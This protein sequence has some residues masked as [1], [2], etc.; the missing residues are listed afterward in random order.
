MHDVQISSNSAL[1][2]K[3]IELV[4]V[5]NSLM[6]LAGKIV[7]ELEGHL[8]Q[9]PR[10]TSLLALAE[11]SRG[12]LPETHLSIRQRRDFLRQSGRA[13]MRILLA[14]MDHPGQVVSSDELLVRS[15]M[16]SQRPASLRVYICLLRRA[17]EDVGLGDAIVT[18]HKGYALDEAAARALAQML[19]DR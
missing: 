18:S 6:S 13:G 16:R 9:D 12:A 8:E 3:I 19:I 2:N 14:L 15:Q 10:Q 17:L 5:A 1:T 11:G 4:A 7:A